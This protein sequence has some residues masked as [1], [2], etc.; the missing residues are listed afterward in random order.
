MKEKLNKKNAK[1]IAIGCGVVAL[2]AV[3]MRLS[4]DVG[5][6]STV[7]YIAGE[8]YRVVDEAGNIVKMIEKVR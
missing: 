7:A 4:F 3:G 8:G 6:L 5:V 1:K 2:A